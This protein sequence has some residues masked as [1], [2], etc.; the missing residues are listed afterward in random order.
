M[1]RIIPVVAMLVL[2]LSAIVNT[3]ALAPSSSQSPVLKWNE[4]NTP[5]TAPLVAPES[6][7]LQLLATD[8]SAIFSIISEG[9]SNHLYRSLEGGQQWDRL[10]PVEQNFVELIKH[11]DNDDVLYY[12]TN[13]DVYRSDDGGVSFSALSLLPGVDGSNRF[14][15]SIA[16]E[17]VGG[18]EMVAAAVASSEEVGTGGVF[19]LKPREFLSRWYDTGLVS[20][21]A[22]ATG[23]IPGC[24][25]E[26]GLVAVG[27]SEGEIIFKTMQGNVNWTGG[28]ITNDSSIMHSLESVK[29]VF[30]PDCSP[31]YVTMLVGL[32]G[33]SGG[34]YRVE[35]AGSPLEVDSHPLMNDSGE[36]ISALDMTERGV[37]LAGTT[38]GKLH[39]SK[40]W[41]ITW[42]QPSKP[43][44]GEV[45]TAAIITPEGFYVAT[46]GTESAVSFSADC[47]SW[48]QVSWI[49]SRVD[50]VL[51][52]AV[53]PDCS[54]N[55][56]V[57]LLTWGGSYSLWQS[58]DGGGNWIR[59]LNSSLTGEIFEKLGLSPDYGQFRQAV[60]LA[61]RDT[62]GKP[63]IWRSDNGGQSFTSR[64]CPLNV[65][66]WEIIGD[67]ALIIGSFDGESGVIL[68]SH[69]SGFSY[70]QAVVGS[71]PVKSLAVAGSEK[72]GWQVL[73]GNTTGDIFFSADSG[74]SFK[75]LPAIP[76]V[77]GSITFAIELNIEEGT[78]IYATSDLTEGGIYYGVV[79]ENMTW[80][81]LEFSGE[82]SRTRTGSIAVSDTGLLY[83]ADLEAL[84][85]EQGWGKVV[86]IL[87]PC[88]GS[89]V[90]EEITEGLTEGNSLEK[91]VVVGDTLWA[92]DITGYRLLCFTDTLADPV[93]LASPQNEEEGVGISGD[94]CASKIKLEW[95][96][97]EG[98]TSYRW[99]VSSSSTFSPIENVIEGL[100]SSTEAVLPEL[101][102][103]NS[104]FWRVRAVSPNISFWSETGKF[105]TSCSTRVVA[106]KL[107]RPFPAEKDVATQPLFQWEKIEGADC[108]EL[109]VA[110]DSNFKE[111]VITCTDQQA[112]YANAWQVPESLEYET[113]YF[114]RV[115]A[116][117]AG[118]VS[119]WSGVGSF[120]TVD[121]PVK[122]DT[123]VKPPSTITVTVPITTVVENGG[124]TVV[125]PT[126]EIPDQ[127][128]VIT[129]VPGSGVSQVIDYSPQYFYVIIA[130]L[131]GVLF[132]MVIVLAVVVAKNRQGN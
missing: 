48:Q 132:V 38:S 36:K 82:L 103:E 106:P 46:I 76:G 93:E 3:P 112:L 120:Q 56:T 117:D 115:R 96:A 67:D 66:C 68:G 4:V 34:I 26:F 45:V 92:M 29:L 5:S 11:P 122:P 57:Y 12:A 51:D 85:H 97:L 32:N 62:N 79:G 31:D 10:A 30:A 94:G 47:D 87:E 23:F 71:T 95:N 90:A 16:V 63:A 27:I 91:L 25:E 55:Q 58:T 53:S 21:D 126:I 89:A 83:A 40:D 104:Y 81:K 130:L 9:K 123:T 24:N 49:D 102:A 78:R 99:Q 44:T 33:E 65:D 100:T 109:V 125:M 20:F 64:G 74:V 98:A 113:S 52:F 111:V 6:D 118:G 73:A 37:I 114:W 19:I 50:A 80:D 84:N 69:N 105:K 110:A 7:V 131:G 86:R 101:E 75:E 2:H 41:G 128:I 119:D 77:G 54:H 121:V 15:N 88:E 61:G 35:A 107:E 17:V 116:V 39:I 22:Y 13:S 70:K 124:I 1:S 28:R 127:T 60:F 108:Y 43:P 129:Q 42:E 14:I 18:E 59:C 72:T 8:D